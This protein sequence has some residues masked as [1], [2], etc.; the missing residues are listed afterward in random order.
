MK[1][2]EKNMATV[3]GNINKFF[4]KDTKLYIGKCPVKVGTKKIIDKD[5]DRTISIPIYEDRDTY[6]P[7]IGSCEVHPVYKDKSFKSSKDKLCLL[8]LRSKYTYT[9]IPVKEEFDVTVKG[10]V[11][12]IKDNDTGFL[13]DKSDYY[14]FY[15]MPIDKSEIESSVRGSMYELLSDADQQ[16]Y[17]LD[18]FENGEESYVMTANAVHTFFVNE[19]DSLIEN[20]NLNQPEADLIVKTHKNFPNKDSFTVHINI[21]NIKKGIYKCNSD[22]F[23]FIYKNQKFTDIF[24][25]V[26]RILK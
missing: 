18:L 24:D 7:Y 19:I 5:F 26:E 21:E 4:R 23:V 6:I 15:H 10:N 3:M 11:M 8:I 20:L 1:V 13:K 2:T 9:C 22:D 14:Y 12:I 25:I 17:Y 16:Y